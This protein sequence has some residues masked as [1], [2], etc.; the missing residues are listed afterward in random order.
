LV[1]TG[2]SVGALYALEE[3]VASHPSLTS[4]NLTGS[5]PVA[6]LELQQLGRLSGIEALCG[7]LR[8]LAQQQARSRSCLSG[9]AVRGMHA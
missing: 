5:M 6:T 3:L 4:V 1:V 8:R 2:P 7:E 9:T